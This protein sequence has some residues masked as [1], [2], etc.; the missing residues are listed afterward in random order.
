VYTEAKENAAL[1]NIGAR[2]TFRD[3]DFFSPKLSHNILA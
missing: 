1:S 2:K 3:K